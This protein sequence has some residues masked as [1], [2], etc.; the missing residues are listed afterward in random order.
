M[1]HDRHER[2][3]R[4]PKL[5]AES[6]GGNWSASPTGDDW[7]RA[8]FPQRP[9]Q[10]IETFCALYGIPY[11]I[12]RTLTQSQIEVNGTALARF[13]FELSG[14]DLHS[15]SIRELTFGTEAPARSR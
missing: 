3:P 15:P 9:A 6:F 10:K 4:H 1:F 13:D 8:T 11:A 7:Y 5:L 2:N 14:D 12:Q